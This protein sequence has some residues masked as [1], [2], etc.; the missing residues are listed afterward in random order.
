V[1]S[2]NAEYAAKSSFPAGFCTAG[3]SS[4]YTAFVI[5]LLVDLVFQVRSRPDHNQWDAYLV[6][7]D[8]CRA[9]VAFLLVPDVYVL[10]FMEIPEAI[11]AL[12]TCQDLRW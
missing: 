8:P 12:R 3:F 9:A 2:S 1:W 6:L 11:R 7:I 4:L 10:P 5:S